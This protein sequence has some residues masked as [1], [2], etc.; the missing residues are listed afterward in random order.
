MALIKPELFN[1]QVAKT[2]LSEATMGISYDQILF[3]TDDEKK[4]LFIV[5]SH[6]GNHGQTWYRYSEEAVKE[7]YH[8]LANNKIAA[9]QYR[10]F[11]PITK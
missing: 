3:L 7:S 11:R 6:I 4:N 1:T 2:F 8:L 9:I 10:L 5:H